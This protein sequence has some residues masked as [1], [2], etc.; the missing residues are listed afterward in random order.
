MYTDIFGVYNAS[1]TRANKWTLKRK[2]AYLHDSKS[3]DAKFED[4]F[5]SLTPAINGYIDLKFV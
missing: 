2:K 5:Y 4:S 1:L 3:V